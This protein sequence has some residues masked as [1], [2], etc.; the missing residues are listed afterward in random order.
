M[1]IRFGAVAR[2]VV[3]EA[4]EAEGVSFSQYVR[5]AALIRAAMQAA[6]LGAPVSAMPELVD[7]ITRA[8]AIIK[9]AELA[10]ED[11]AGG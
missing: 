3:A 1:T 9:A 5:E 8:R 4:A 7:E 6:R 10:G 11:P 2:A